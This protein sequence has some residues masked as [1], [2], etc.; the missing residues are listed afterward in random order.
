VISARGRAGLPATAAADLAIAGLTVGGRAERALVLAGYD[1]AGAPVNGQASIGGVRV[2][3]DWVA[4]SLV[5]GAMTADLSTAFGTAT[6]TEIGGADTPEDR[7][8]R[9]ASIAIGGQAAGTAG[10]ADHFGFVAEQVGSLSV[11]GTAIP[12]H[13]GASNDGPLAVGPTGDLTLFEVT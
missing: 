4:S 12:L 7:L 9:V 10:G 8:A 2:G 1:P 6:D 13:S 3:G 11:G 5:A